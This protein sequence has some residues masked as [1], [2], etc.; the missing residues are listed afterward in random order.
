MILASN[1]AWHVQFTV[2]IQMCFDLSVNVTPLSFNDLN[3]TSELLFGVFRSLNHTIYT[4]SP[5][6]AIGAF[7]LLTYFPS[8]LLI[9]CSTLQAFIYWTIKES[10][11]IFEDLLY[12]FEDITVS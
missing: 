7:N 12:T 5:E 1:I 6:I 3:N 10:W 2:P 8:S 9:C 4:L 11:Y